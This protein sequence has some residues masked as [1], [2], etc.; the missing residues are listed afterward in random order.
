[1]DKRRFTPGFGHTYGVQGTWPNTDSPSRPRL[2]SPSIL[3]AVMIRYRSSLHIGRLD[4]GRR[5]SSH[6][7]PWDWGR[8]D[9]VPGK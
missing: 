2:R 9:E 1:M 8:L 4:H 7:A 6:D 5:I 3:A